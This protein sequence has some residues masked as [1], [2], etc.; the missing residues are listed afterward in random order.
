MLYRGIILRGLSW[1]RAN[2]TLLIFAVLLL[3]FS[4]SVV[5]S[6]VPIIIKPFGE[7]NIKLYVV[8]L[9][10]VGGHGVGN[11]T[12]MVEGILDAC[13]I[14]PIHQYA[15]S[16]EPITY[17]ELKINA[18]VTVV[19]D[20]DQYKEIVESCSKAII[21]NAHGETIPVPSNYSKEAW[22]DKIADAMAKR[23]VTWVHTT[24]YPFYY[25]YNEGS[26][27]DEW[28]EEG[29]QRLMNHTGKT[30]VRC[31][32]IYPDREKDLCDMNV[33]ARSGLI[34]DW[35]LLGKAVRVQICK[36]LNGSDFNDKVV[37]PIWGVEEG[38]MTGAVI[39]F[40]EASTMNSFGYYVHIGTYQTYDENSVP[41]DADRFRGYTGAAAA[42]GTCAWRFATR[43]AISESEKAIIN[44]ENEGRTKGLDDACRLLQEAKNRAPG[45]TA[46]IQA[47]EAMDAANSATK[48]AFAEAYP[49]L[50]MVLGLVGATTMSG[51]LIMRRK[52]PRKKQ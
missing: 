12:R 27:E 50:L 45:I 13:R 1:K 25:Y 18:S 5:H 48:P 26:S 35:T 14:N 19:R 31:G 6:Y 8:A 23:N 24:G 51:F 10:D 43:N 33:F 36:P 21:V 30:D 15:P 9:D 40:T 44:A 39:K 34:S 42:I 2:L 11:M 41:T 3:L 49:F 4:N 29:F 52:N 37:L 46:I 22:V 47:I 16:A 38:Y 20:W 17:A 7:V 32:Y 28:G